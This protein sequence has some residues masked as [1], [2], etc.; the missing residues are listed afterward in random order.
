M[1]SFNRPT[2]IQT[3]VLDLSPSDKLNHGRPPGLVSFKLYVCMQ[4]MS[5]TRQLGERLLLKHFSNVYDQ[6]IQPCYL[7]ESSELVINK[8]CI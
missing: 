8:S 1:Y 2:S 7:L 5:N 3:V 4:C 6:T